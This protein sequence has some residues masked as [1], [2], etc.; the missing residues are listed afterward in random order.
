[1]HRKF[2]EEWM[3]GKTPEDF[4]ILEHAGGRLLWPVKLHRLTANKTWREEDAYLQTL[5]GLD[6]VEALKMARAFFEERG[7]KHD[8]PANA[9]AWQEVLTH[10]Y[11]A[12]ALREPKPNAAGIH[13]QRHTLDH[14]LSSKESGIQRSEVHSLHARMLLFETFEEARLE[15]L[16]AEEVV[17]MAMA[18]AEV[19][20][21][22]PLVATAGPALDT[23][24]VSSAVLLTSY[25]LQERSSP[26]PG[27]STQGRSGQKKHKQS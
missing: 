13:G 23:Y 12:L 27:S 16:P 7:L 26:S 2:I 14:L 8:D 4:E 21:P 6:R 25:L 24:V 9:E 3:K 15:E 1:M 11:V 19:K 18:I 10:A 22:S 5:D 17:A 20:N